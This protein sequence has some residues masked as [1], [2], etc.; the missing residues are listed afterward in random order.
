MVTVN[1][2]LPSASALQA[3]VMQRALVLQATRAGM[4]TLVRTGEAARPALPPAEPPRPERPAPH[5]AARVVASATAQAA[6]QHLAGDALSAYAQAGGE[7]P[8]LAVESVARAGVNT[9]RDGPPV[10][11]RA[12]AGPQTSGPNGAMP[13][14]GL[15]GLFTASARARVEEGDSPR[16]SRSWSL[17]WWGPSDGSDR[18]EH[19]TIPM[20]HRLIIAAA[21]IAAGIAVAA[22][23]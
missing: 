4:E 18:K 19:G 16:R 2:K 3:Q 9:G 14:Q 15:V 20:K 21:L 13:S 17:K 10:P 5:I 23:L 22:M 7:V 12:E 8:S 1:P 11:P 6:A